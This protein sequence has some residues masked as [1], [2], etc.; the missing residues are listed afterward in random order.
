MLLDFFLIVG[1]K[2]NAVVLARNAPITYY[3]S[4]ETNMPPRLWITCLWTKR[5]SLTP[6]LQHVPDVWA[7]HVRTVQRCSSATPIF[8]TQKKTFHDGDD[9]DDSVYYRNWNVTA[10]WGKT[11][12]TTTTQKK[13]KKKAANMHAHV[14]L[15]LCRETKLPF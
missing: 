11:N 4:I 14:C 15:I 5:L 8:H 3:C 1:K 12:E 6:R 13:K 7:I 10:L 2:Q 9:D